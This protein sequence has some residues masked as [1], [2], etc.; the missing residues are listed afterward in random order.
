[1]PTDTRTRKPQRP[2]RVKAAPRPE[3]PMGGQLALEVWGIVLLALAGVCV[4]SLARGPEGRLGGAL[5]SALVK[6]LGRGA[7]TMPALW[8]LTGLLMLLRRTGYL[9]GVRLVGVLA[10]GLA[11]VIGFDIAL[12]RSLGSLMSFR[13]YL[14][15]APHDAGGGWVGALGAWLLVRLVG[16]TGSAIVLVAM[17]V[18]GL[19]TA[20]NVPVVV[21][22]SFVVRTVGRGLGFVFRTIRVAYDAMV[23]Y[24]FEVDGQARG[25]A[26]GAR[27][28][29]SEAEAAKAAS[30]A[31]ARAPAEA[32]DG[33]PVVAGRRRGGA[34]LSEGVGA[35][36]GAGSRASEAGLRAAGLAGPAGP[37]GE[38]GRVRR[39]WELTGLSRAFDRRGA[40]PRG[41]RR[42]RDGCRRRARREGR[43]VRQDGAAEADRR[44]RVP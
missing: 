2:A 27:K 20:T 12:H 9:V 29:D 42:A 10:A 40:R 19:S 13:D 31:R 7:Y 37:G 5:A 32:C 22:A 15:H 38:A 26:Q 3:Q 24:L 41:P 17:G 16:V 23:L 33:E 14:A 30:T 4:I 43:A 28:G 34:S 39:P 6:A 8:C 25:R 11:L 44:F 36:I 1:M 21:A 35:D 18:A